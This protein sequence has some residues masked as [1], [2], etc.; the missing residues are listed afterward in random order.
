MNMLPGTPA[1][2]PKIVEVKKIYWEIDRKMD[3]ELNSLEE[4]KELAAL[5]EPSSENRCGLA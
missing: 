3:F 1:S 5:S 2:E 4:M